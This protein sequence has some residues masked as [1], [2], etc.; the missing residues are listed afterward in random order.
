M[1]IALVWRCSRRNVLRCLVVFLALQIHPVQA[2][3]CY[4]GNT[5]DMNFGTVNSSGGMTNSPVIVICQPDHSGGQTFYYQVCVF[6]TLGS[7]SGGQPTRR[8]TNYM[9]DYLNYDLFGDPAH[10]QHVGPPGTT[11][12]LQRQIAASPAT[13]QTVD[14]PIYGLVYPGQSVPA[15]HPFQE[16]GMTTIVHFRYSTAGFP[17]SADCMTGGSGGGSFTLGSAGIHATFADSCWVAA[18]DIDFGSTAPP[19][20]ALRENGNI[21]VQCAPGTVWRIGLDN[22]QNFD[23]SMRRMAGPGGYVRYQLYL[24]AANTEVWGNDDTD[25]AVGTTDTAGNT[26]SLTVYGAVPAQPNLAVGN[27]VDTIVVTLYY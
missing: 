13:P 24:D 1:P 23:G 25:M 11:P 5:F 21:R 9:G 18:T 4:P 12:V 22:G 10:T 14:I 20:S 15:T 19:Q 26:A 2:Q 27:Y 6:I 8:M 3:S 16:Q 7:S 17:V